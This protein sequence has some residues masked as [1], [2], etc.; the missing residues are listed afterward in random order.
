MKK[1][2]NILA[3]ALLTTLTLVLCIGLSINAEVVQDW[4]QIYTEDYTGVENGPVSADYIPT[5]HYQ[6]GANIKDEALAVSTDNLSYIQFNDISSVGVINAPQNNHGITQQWYNHLPK[7]LTT[8]YTIGGVDYMYDG[9]YGDSGVF[10]EEIAGK[11][12]V[13][14]FTY[15]VGKGTLLRTNKL[16]YV[17]DTSLYAANENSFDVEIEYYMT[18]S[19]KDKLLSFSYIRSD[20]GASSV[21]LPNDNVQ[22]GKWATWSFSVNNADFSK[23]VLSG[24]DTYNFKLSIPGIADSKTNIEAI[25]NY[26]EVKGRDPYFE[27]YIHSIRISRKNHTPVPVFKA[28]QKTVSIPF[29]AEAF[30]DAKLSFDMLLPASEPIGTS[31][32]NLGAGAFRM[33]ISNENKLD[34][35]M[36][37]IENTGETQKISTISCDSEGIVTKKEIYSGNILDKT[38]TYTILLDWRDKTY[39]VEIKEG[40]QTLVSET[41][42]CNIDNIT[43]IPGNCIASYFTVKCADGST[44]IIG[45]YDNFTLSVLDDPAYFEAKTDADAIDNVI[46]TSGIANENTTL[47]L[48]GSVNGSVFTWVSSDDAIL[49]L[50]EDGASLTPIRGDADQEAK[51]T[52]TSTLRGIKFI[53]EYT[54]TVPEHE[55]NKK[56]K[57]DRDALTLN[58]PPSLKVKEDF[59]LPTKGT[60]NGADITWGSSDVGAISVS[61]GIATVMRSEFD[62]PVTL[63]ASVTVGTF[64]AE[65]T[66]D[67]IVTALNN[68]HAEIGNITETEAGGM[69]SATVTVNTP[70]RTGNITFTAY[71]IDASGEIR[72]RKTDTTNIT[73]LYSPVTFSVSGLNKAPGD[74]VKYYFWDD[75][76]TPLTNNAPTSISDLTASGRVKGVK[77]SWSASKDDNN[78]IE[79]YAIYR[80]GTL[81]DQTVFTSYLD[82]TAEFDTEYDY[83]VIPVDTNELSGGC[84]ILAAKTNVKMYFIDYEKSTDS[85]NFTS[86]IL[87]HS[88]GG[89]L[90]AWN[91]TQLDGVE[92]ATAIKGKA[93]AVQASS[94]FTAFG[95][96]ITIE[97]SYFDNKATLGIGYMSDPNTKGT[98]TVPDAGKDT[99]VWKTSVIKCPTAYL[100]QHNKNSYGDFLF[101]SSTDDLY[102]RKVRFVTSKLYD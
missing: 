65:K 62:A 84:N 26:Y 61:N 7:A 19:N 29:N 102:I 85:D 38:L 9:D 45:L 55:D 37:E 67:I 5:P 36:L 35:A 31:S 53:K 22:T 13:K 28:N 4:R 80:D 33:G 34:A 92:C 90:V 78:A 100:I 66:F 44:P 77:L 20:M 32:Y 98:V 43:S 8:P 30:G 91:I 18:P 50:G 86:G 11:N 57:A 6:F 2:K 76:G 99:G 79:Y 15:S 82:K 83:Q 69:L 17:T 89:S 52:L 21:T 24:S 12:A 97:I 49:E 60:I 81:I 56:A 59:T 27:T 93:I 72:D 42:P 63:T 14:M 41:L 88:P 3:K 25:E 70:G 48:I 94:P 73:S 1:T 47:P 54:I 75:E 58:L 39:T 10:Y 96:D 68:V 16:C 51:L 71:S 23:T 87:T 46:I 40:A 95:E 101:S 74:T 64:T